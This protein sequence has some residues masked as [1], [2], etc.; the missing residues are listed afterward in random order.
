MK[1]F[2]SVLFFLLAWHF[3]TQ[4]SFIDPGFYPSPFKIITNLIQLLKSDNDFA[5]NII[6]SL[7]RLIWASL[8]TFPI[9]I[10]LALL[11]STN[12]W[13]DNLLNPF[14]AITF[15]LPKVAIYPL[16][17]LVFG[18]DE[19]SKVALI[20]VGIF[21]P[22]FINSRLGFKKILNSPTAEIL[23]I[24]PLKTFDY[25]WHYLLKGSQL[26]ILTGLKLALNYGLTLVVV[27]ETTASNNGLGYF[28][29]RS[30]DQ[31]KLINVY[32]SIFLLSAFGATFYY[33]L[34]YFIQRN[35]QKYF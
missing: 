5:L 33:G 17:L 1:S 29:W 24:Y 23:K 30:W 28:I 14:V 15:P 35:R 3:L 20:A 31:F 13:F 18:I 26:E 27:S 8:L 9:A 7:K 16:M 32:S 21:Y 2:L 12:R 19:K 6:F 10:L 34:D 11:T 25:C 22:V 4:F